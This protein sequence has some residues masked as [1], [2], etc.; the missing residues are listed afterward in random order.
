LQAIAD[1]QDRH[2]AGKNPRV[3]VWRVRVVHTAGPAGQDD[4]P[5][6]EFLDVGFVDLLERVN[7]AVNPRFAHPAGN[8]LGY[9]GPE[10]DDQQ[11]VYH[12]PI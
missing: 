7:F 8:E 6:V 10:I 2:L 3:A 12:G 4:A 11:T 5:W 9:L 1:A